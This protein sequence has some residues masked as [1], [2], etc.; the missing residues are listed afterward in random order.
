MS[1]DSNDG[2]EP[3][4]TNRVLATGSRILENIMASNSEAPNIEHY[5]RDNTTFPSTLQSSKSYLPV[6]PS[7]RLKPKTGR[8]QYRRQ[9]RSLAFAENFEKPKRRTSKSV[10][11]AKYFYAENKTKKVLESQRDEE[12]FAKIFSKTASREDWAIL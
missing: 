2:K 11:M 10:N 4:Q 6:P 5:A 3:G 8:G 1:K 12:L 9:Q 7:K